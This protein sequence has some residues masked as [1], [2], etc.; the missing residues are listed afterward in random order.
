M[1]GKEI[2]EFV[3]KELMLWRQVRVNNAP[4]DSTDRL[5]AGIAAKKTTTP[6]TVHRR[7]KLKSITANV[8]LGKEMDDQKV[9]TGKDSGRCCSIYLDNGCN[10]SAIVQ[11]YLVSDKTAATPCHIFLLHPCTIF[12]LFIFVD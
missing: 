9:T 2:K 11:R 6:V 1:E 10:Y 3:E 4:K 8:I 5:P 12:T 7:E